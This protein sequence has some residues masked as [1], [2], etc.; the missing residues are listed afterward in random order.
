MITT[1]ENRT[2]QIVRT[3]G[4]RILLIASDG[5]PPPALGFTLHLSDRDVI[6]LAAALCRVIAP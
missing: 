5:N 3:P 1:V 4:G 2:I 6:E